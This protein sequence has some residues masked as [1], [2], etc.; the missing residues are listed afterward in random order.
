NFKLN[1]GGTIKYITVKNLTMNGTIDFSSC[2]M[3]DEE[4]RI[5]VHR[6]SDIQVGDILFA[7]ISP[8]GRCHLITE[9][10]VDWDINESVFSV[11]PNNKII[12]SIFL[13]MTFISE[14]FVK[15][16]E[17][18][19]AGSVFKGLRITELQRLDTI[20]PPKHVLVAFDK[21][22]KCLFEMNST[23][24][25]ENQHLAALR[26]FLLPLLM[27]GQVTVREAEKT[28]P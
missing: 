3:I 5:I 6:R 2:D 16:A 27:N 17:R 4:A 14:S 8:L 9:K 1:T 28:A 24:F 11:R 25:N 21:Q 12:T 13:Y 19:S 20:L 18:N 7:S 22:L 10:P 23:I 26:D 15:K